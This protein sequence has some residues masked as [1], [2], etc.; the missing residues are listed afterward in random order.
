MH[1]AKAKEDEVLRKSSDALEFKGIEAA[2]EDESDLTVIH[3]QI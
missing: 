1:F 3:E 2:F